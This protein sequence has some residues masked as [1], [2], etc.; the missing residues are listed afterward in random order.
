MKNKKIALLIEIL[1]FVGVMGAITFAYYFGGKD[2]LEEDSKEVALIKIDD[3]NFDEEVLKSSKPVILEFY[4]NSCPP[5]ITMVPTMISISKN[6]SDIK[7]ASVNTSEDGS[8]QIVEEYKIDAYPTIIVF[9][10]GKVVK[11]FIGVT[12]EEDLVAAAK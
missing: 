6:H 3:N 11:Q 2:N 4:S 5:C 12:S 10:D 8:S 7:V 9:K 1:L